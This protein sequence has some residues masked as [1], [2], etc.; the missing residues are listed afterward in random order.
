M[1]GDLRH[2]IRANLCPKNSSGGQ[3]QSGFKIDMPHSEM[4]G[5]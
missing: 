4:R 1:I 3:K 5:Q 2:K